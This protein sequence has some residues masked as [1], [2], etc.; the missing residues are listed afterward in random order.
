[1]NCLDNQAPPLSGIPDRGMMLAPRW[2]TEAP[3]TIQNN[4]QVVLN[5][6]PEIMLI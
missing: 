1:M 5:G 6:L 3:L 4:T 2:P